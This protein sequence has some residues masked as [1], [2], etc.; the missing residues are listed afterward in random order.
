MSVQD[1]D[2]G[3]RAIKDNLHQVNNMAA[4]VGVFDPRIAEYAAYNEYG[5]AKIPS[6]PFTA[7]AFDTAKAQLNADV[8]RN[9]KL[10]LARKI[11]AR[12]ALSTLGESH[13]R[14]VRYWIVGRNIPPSLAVST[15]KRKGHS[16]TLVDSGDLARSIKFM[17]RNRNAGRA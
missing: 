17:I 4:D 2:K 16:K 6:R 15:V 10:M 12:Q 8:M 1:V 7:L 14:R 3:W 13:A 11:N 9:I 5:T